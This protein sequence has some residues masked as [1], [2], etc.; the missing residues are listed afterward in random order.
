ME[1][2]FAKT[3]GNIIRRVETL[4]Y[5]D[6]ALKARIRN[7]KQR[8]DFL[9]HHYW[10]ERSVYFATD[11]GRALMQKELHE[12]ANMFGI[13]DTDIEAAMKPARE[14]LGIDDE[15]WEAQSRI[16]FEQLKSE[17]VWE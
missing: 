4:P 14:R 6:D 5:F 15:K 13:I 7:A 3:M 12:D 9:T 16:I 8:R 10:R 17:V 11:R 2:Q 1:N